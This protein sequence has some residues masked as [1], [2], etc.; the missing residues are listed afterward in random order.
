[1]DLQQS[2]SLFRKAVLKAKADGFT[3]DLLDQFPV[4]CCEFASYLLAKFLIEKVGISPLIIVTGE[5]RF[6]K[7]QRHV[8]LRFYEINIDI[9]ANQFSSTS[10]TIFADV[11]S[12]WHQRFKIIHAEKP[13]PKLMKLNQEA[14]SA[15]LYDYK[16]ILGYIERSRLH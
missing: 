5:N 9:T 12:A 16:K 6:K 3:F 1:M 15:L 8:W 11:G 14:R 4:G 13:D 7:S 10:R 2:V